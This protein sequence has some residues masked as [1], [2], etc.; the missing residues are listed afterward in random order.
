MFTI[1]LF[2]YFNTIFIHKKRFRSIVPRDDSGNH[3][4]S[5]HLI[6]GHKQ[7]LIWNNRFFFLFPYTWSFCK[8]TGMSRVKSFSS[9][10]TVFQSCGIVFKL[11]SWFYATSVSSI[12]TTIIHF[13]HFGNFYSFEITKASSFYHSS[14]WRTTHSSFFGN[15]TRC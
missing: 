13:I 14:N 12:A 5:R 7:V 3:N 1:I 4:F 9:C 10:H 15:F 11:F 2:I 6:R 8:L